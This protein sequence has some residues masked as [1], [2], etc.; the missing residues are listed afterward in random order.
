M[1]KQTTDICWEKILDYSEKLITMADNS[2]WE[3]MPDIAIK[4]DKLIKKYFSNNPTTENNAQRH[5][6]NILKLLSLD[7]G[8]LNNYKKD[9]ASL[10]D[11]Y[12]SL[13]NANK[14]VTAYHNCP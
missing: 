2:E 6:K 13:R 14:A 1:S 11:D 8:I 7:K 4:R 5:Q 10:S 9:H 12:A 3:A